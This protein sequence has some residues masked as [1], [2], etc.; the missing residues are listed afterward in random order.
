MLPP[1]VSLSLSDSIQNSHLPLSL[2]LSL[3]HFLVFHE[4]EGSTTTVNFKETSVYI[5]LPSRV[6]TSFI[7]C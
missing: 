4:E 5:S 1:T 3:V 6:G 7:P 2:S